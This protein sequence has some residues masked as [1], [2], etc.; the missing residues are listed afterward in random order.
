MTR[1]LNCVTVLGGRFALV[2]FA[3]PAPA[4]KGIKKGQEHH[5]SGKIVSVQSAGKGGQGSL[6]LHVTHHKHK[7]GTTVTVAKGVNKT[8]T[9]NKHTKVDGHM[10]KLTGLAALRPGEQ[11]TVYAHQQHA[12][13]VVIHQHHKKAATKIA[14]R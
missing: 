7:K 6:T 13:V 3:G 14:K 4:A 2:L 9:I 10:G 12:D 1:F 5:L 11:V 8:F